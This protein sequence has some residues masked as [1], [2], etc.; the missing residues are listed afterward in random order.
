MKMRGG[1]LLLISA[2]VTLAVA[3]LAFLIDPPK[4]A[5]KPLPADPKQLAKRIAHN[6]SDWH[7]SAALAENALDM[8]AQNRVAVWQAAHDHAALLAPLR[9]EPANAFARAAFFHWG[10][11][12]AQQ[13]HDALAAFATVLRDPDAFGRMA[14]PL[15]ELTGDLHYLEAVHPPTVNAVGL[16]I[17]IALPNGLFADY[18]ELRGEL[19]RRRLEEFNSYRQ[20]VTPNELVARFP[21]PPYH[22]DSE[23]LMTALFNEL[24]RRPLMDD[25]HRAGA[26]DAILTYALRHD[27]GPL[28]GFEVITRTPGSASVATQI[29]LA[30]KLGMTTAVRQLELAMSDPRH[31]PA[32]PAPAEWQGLCESDICNRAWRTIDAEHGVAISIETVQS[33]SVPAYVEIYLDDA[34]RAEGE[35]GAKR[36]FVVPAGSR[37][38]HR[39]EVVLTNPMT[40]NL[41]RRRVHVASIT[42]L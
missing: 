27:L 5:W 15:F 35:A 37:G 4:F 13:Q 11:L 33:D 19:Q 17:S 2:A 7:A 39:L 8:P 40:R 24:H 3:A 22:T 31:A 25:P 18:R 9:P 12:S 1:R 26:V 16:L 36:D 23:P 6:P 30:R 14:K 21:E 29:E 28:D 42:T 32:A 20:T 38:E 41:Y 34:L 10:E